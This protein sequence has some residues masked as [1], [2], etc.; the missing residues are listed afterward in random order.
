MEPGGHYPQP[1][2][3]VPGKNTVVPPV[4][5]IAV[6]VGILAL[7]ILLVVLL[8]RLFGG[9]ASAENVAKDFVVAVYEGEGERAC[10]LTAPAMRQAELDRFEVSDC[11]EFGEAVA[12][13]PQTPDQE[14]ADVEVLEVDEQGDTATVRVSAPSGSPGTWVM[15]GLE[16]YDD[17]WLVA[18]YSG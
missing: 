4:I 3:P 5:A 17:E 12:E 13:D 14:A 10:E 2:E 18:D 8:L 15:V 16:R 7:V 1:A 9:P 6:G 11:A